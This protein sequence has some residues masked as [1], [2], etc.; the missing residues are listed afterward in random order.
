[1]TSSLRASWIA[2]TTVVLAIAM[3][4]CG[5]PKDEAQND[6]SAATTTSEA[7]ET[8]AAPAPAAE[9]HY[10]IV[11][12]IRD[13]NITETAVHQGDPGTPTLQLPVPPGWTDAGS[14]APKW[15]WGA[16]VST[17]P[18]FVSDPP[19]IIALMSKLVGNVDPAK[20]LEYAP[21]ELRN[22]P[23][24]QNQGEGST[25]QLS[26]FDA[27]QIGGS[28]LKNGA[29]RLIAQKTVVIPGADGLFVLQLNADGTENQMRALMEVT[30]AI[31]DGAVITP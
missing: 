10:T 21:N 28:Y 5:A 19:S 13:N 29:T 4:G 16:I 1:M 11:D 24:Y 27:Y 8:S 22:L 6:D 23:G 18:A 15:A 12:Y 25:S 2:S 7:G 31:D 9:H 14:S 26:G 3:A 20:I 17:D 30:K